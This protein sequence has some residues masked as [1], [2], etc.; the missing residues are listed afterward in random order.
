MLPIHREWRDGQDIVDISENGHNEDFRE[1]EIVCRRTVATSM[2]GMA[3]GGM[4]GV[5][6]E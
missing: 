5:N 6:V 4:V 1:F 3:D 2:C